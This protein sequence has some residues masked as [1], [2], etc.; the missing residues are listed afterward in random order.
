[1]DNMSSALPI[2]GR[3]YR[4][5]SDEAFFVITVHEDEGFIDV[6]DEHGD[7]DEFSFDEWQRMRMQP[8]EPSELGFSGETT[9]VLPVDAL[10]YAFRAMGPK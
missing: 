1:M 2:E 9:V 3:W 8:G 4:H 7:V 10:V 6:R 5:R